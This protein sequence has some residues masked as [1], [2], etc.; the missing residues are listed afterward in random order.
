V[1]DV[2]LVAQVRDA[3]GVDASRFVPQVEGDALD[4]KFRID[5]P[6]VDR[7]G[8]GA[9]DWVDNCPS[10]AN[11]SQLDT[12]GNGV[13]D[14]CRCLPV[15]C[16]A[17][18]AC[19]AVG[20]CQPTTG[21]CTSPALPDGTACPL[22][23]A[24]ASCRAVAAA[25][26]CETDLAG[27]VANCGA[28]ARACSFPGAV[29]VPIFDGYGTVTTYDYNC[30]GVIEGYWGGN[31][32]SSGAPLVRPPQGF[33]MLGPGLTC[34]FAPGYANADGIT[35]GTGSAYITG[36]TQSGLICKAHYA[37]A[38]I[39]GCHRAIAPRRR[40]RGH[41]D[42]TSNGPQQQARAGLR[43]ERL[44]PALVPVHR[45]RL[46]LRRLA[47]GPRPLGRL[48]RDLPPPLTPH[49]PEGMV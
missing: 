7:N 2:Q 1:A 42:R 48:H 31:A 21:T 49:A 10:L 33:C 17:A 15:T 20:V 32:N 37:S 44:R 19:H 13:G 43:A 30:N 16:T 38:G 12:V 24:G 4:I 47:A 23:Q 45:P 35:C 14:A 40:A 27:D 46:D 41:A 6:A 18:D 5:R 34:F 9:F 29:A 26:G 25:T 11:T 8:D 28:C 22:P 39:W 3:A 36:C